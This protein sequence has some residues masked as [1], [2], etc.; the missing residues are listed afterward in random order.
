MR[1]AVAA[2]RPAARRRSGGSAGSPAAT[3]SR[4]ARGATRPAPCRSR[5]RSTPC[6]ARPPRCSGTCSA[7]CPASTRPT[8]SRRRRCRWPAR[9]TRI[10]EQVVVRVDLP[11]PRVLRIPRVVH[12]H[13]PLRD[14]GERI[15]REVGRLRFE[16][17]VVERQRIEVGLDAL[18][19]LGRRPP[20][21]RALALRGEAE[22][23]QHFRIDLDHDRVGVAAQ[24]RA[25]APIRG[26]PC[27]SCACT[28]TTRGSS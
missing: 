16:R 4:R 13:R 21:R 7:P 1:A 18:A 5:S 28:G 3:R 25:A 19:Q 17:R 15:A 22:L 14:R 12:R 9:V 27:S 26:S 24:P 20:R 6:P 8:S 2:V 23:L 10:D 11:Q